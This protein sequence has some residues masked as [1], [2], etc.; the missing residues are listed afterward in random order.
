MRKEERMGEGEGERQTYPV[1]IMYVLLL[2]E[3]VNAEI[4]DTFT[5][6]VNDSISA[7]F[8]PSP[9][10]YHC[11]FSSFLFFFIFFFFSSFGSPCGKSTTSIRNSTDSSTIEPFT[12]INN[13][14]CENNGQKREKR[15]RNTIITADDVLRSAMSIGQ[16]ICVNEPNA[17]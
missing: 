7:Y 4:C 9:V 15:K 3:G 11:Q 10:N 13:I 14:S 1:V 8:E 16:P 2:P 12:C 5:A 17:S 6:L